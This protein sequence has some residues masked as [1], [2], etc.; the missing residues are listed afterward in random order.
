M[1]NKGVGE[2]DESKEMLKSLI[3]AMGMGPAM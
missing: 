3:W 2:E 1:W